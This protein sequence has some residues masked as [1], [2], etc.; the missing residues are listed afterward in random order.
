MMKAALPRSTVLALAVGLLVVGVTVQAKAQTTASD[1]TNLQITCTGSTV[2]SPGAVSLIT[3]N[4][5]P[6][7][8]LN[9]VGSNGLPGVNRHGSLFLVV[10]IPG[11][12]SLSFTANGH[13]TTFSGS[14][15]GSPGFLMLNKGHP[16]SGLLPVKAGDTGNPT[17][18]NFVGAS[19]Q[20]GTTPISFT[21]DV[22]NLGAYQGNNVV[23]VSL[24]IA[25][26]GTK[27]PAGTVFYSFLTNCDPTHSACGSLSGQVAVNSTS[28]GNSL[29][30]V[31]EPGS[32]ALY[33]MA[34]IALGSLLARSE[35]REKL[36]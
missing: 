7:F 20:S 29:S 28:I 30:V 10:L 16:G 24:A 17:F 3:S 8:T 19:A 11:A 12:S 23:N 25:S 1:P 27:F 14:W 36:I 21:V 32:A 18:N 31:P 15:S 26:G 5:L 2:C 35:R 33:G 22:F 34:L 13:S 4:T 6:T 9:A